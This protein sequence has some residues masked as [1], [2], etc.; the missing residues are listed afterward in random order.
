MALIKCPECGKEVSDKSEICI[1]C[2]Y[3]IAKYAKEQEQVTPQYE[4]KYGRQYGI[5]LGESKMTYDNAES[6]SGFKEANSRSNIAIF[7]SIISIIF[8][9]PLPPLSFL[10]ALLTIIYVIKSIHSQNQ[11]NVK[12]VISIVISV[13]AVLVSIIALM[14]YDS[15]STSNEPGT[16]NQTNISDS[17]NTES[18]SEETKLWVYADEQPT[19]ELSVTQTTETESNY[20]TET[21]TMTE[22]ASESTA[23]DIESMSEEDYKNNCTELWNEDIFFGETNLKGS[24]VK[25][26]LFIEEPYTFTADDMANSISYK[27][28]T[29]N[30]LQKNF[31]KC[32]VAISD[33]E[34]SYVGGQIS[35]FFSDDNSLQCYDYNLGSHIYVYGK[36]VDY[37]T[38]TWDG[39][40]VCSIIP[41]YIES[42]N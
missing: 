11:G 24:Y 39:Y 31:F 35:L 8:C 14:V 26:K 6:E 2:G 20:E 32:G 3:P 16:I 17:Y 4:D 33:T 36:I 30:N 41:K 15:E 5:N 22:I 23:I 1:G 29:D 37:S 7:F 21:E 18:E 28:I 9:I 42:A 27:F 13:I 19:E 34:K 40:N 38:N 25:L 12:S 10:V